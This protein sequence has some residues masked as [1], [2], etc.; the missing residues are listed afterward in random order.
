MT[1]HRLAYLTALAAVGFVF[2]ALSLAYVAVRLEAVE[3]GLGSTLFMR[4]AFIVPGALVAMLS[5]S[6]VPDNALSA[7]VASSL[8][9]LAIGASGLT[10]MPSLNALLR[11]ALQSR[12][13]PAAF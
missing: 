7:C 9:M 1:A 3:A 6:A 2:E 10:M 12:A 8:V 11:R 5:S 13:I 4:S